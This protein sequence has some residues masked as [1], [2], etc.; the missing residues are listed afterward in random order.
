MPVS[1]FGQC[2]DLTNL[3]NLSKKYNIPIIEDAAQSFG[4]T[5]NKRRSCNFGT[6][7][8][9]SF[10]QVNLSAVMEMEEHVLPMITKLQIK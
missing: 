3:E 8:C 5:H 10:F 2:A 9:T 4:A 6:I 1:I 7:G